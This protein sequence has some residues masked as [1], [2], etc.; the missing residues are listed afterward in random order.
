MNNFNFLP[1]R[2]SWLPRFLVK[3]FCMAPVFFMCLGIASGQEKKAK[4]KESFSFMASAH[5]DDYFPDL[6]GKSIDFM[7]ERRMWKNLYLKGDIFISNNQIIRGPKDV[8]YT[9]LFGMNVDQYA[10][11]FIG[12]TISETRFKRE[13]FILNRTVFQLG[14]GYRFGKKN[15]FIPE[16][17]LSIGSGYK[18][19]LNIVELATQGDSIRYARSSADFLRARISGYYVSFGYAIRLKHDL[20][21]QPTMRFY[22]IQNRSKVS[23][24]FGG[25]LDLSGASL[26]VAI[27]KDFYPKSAR[28][29]KQ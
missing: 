23:S 29:N 5:A 16:V 13:S 26:G 3:S 10:N 28:K 4:S 14:L 20:Y 15:Q 25:L 18:A 8:A 19:S 11:Y 7:Y 9:A 6:V 1:G 24:G 17:G 2:A 27:R 21:L 22:D 12:R